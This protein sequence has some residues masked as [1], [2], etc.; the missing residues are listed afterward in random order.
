MG[1]TANVL[2]PWSQK[3]QVGITFVDIQHEQLVD[4]INALHQ[5]MVAGQGRQVV[6]KAVE[7]LILYAQA[8]FNEEEKVLE[9]CGYPEFPALHIENERLKYAVMV[10]HQK[11]MTYELGLND[12][13]MGFL[14][15]WL[16]EH[17]HSVDTKCVLF[18]K[19]KGVT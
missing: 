3:Y 18:L 15:D 16:A 12:A 7:K 14:K 1:T 6:G 2:F 5:A 4:I 9:S 10:F 8:H 17:I 11:L 19:D 13:A